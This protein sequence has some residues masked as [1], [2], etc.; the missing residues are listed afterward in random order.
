MWR[1]S[2][3]VSR[4]EALTY[5]RDKHPR[6]V[7]R[8]PGVERYV[9]DHCLVGPDGKEPQYAGIGELWFA[10]VDAAKRALA[11]PEWQSVLDDAGTFMDLGAESALWAEEHPIF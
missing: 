4:E 1:P 7:E 5:W 6:L 3:G 11:T 8:V 2:E 9:Q 10:S